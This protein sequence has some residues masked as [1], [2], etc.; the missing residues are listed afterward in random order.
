MCSLLCPAWVHRCEY[1]L[2]GSSG[3]FFSSSV[4][5]SDWMCTLSVRSGNQL[6]FWKLS[7]KEF[8]VFSVGWTDTDLH[9]FFFIWG[10]ED[11]LQPEL[12]QT[13][14]LSSVNGYR[15]FNV[16]FGEGSFI[17]IFFSLRYF[18]SCKQEYS[19]EGN[20]LILQILKGRIQNKFLLFL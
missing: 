17:G 20:F 10:I 3:S 13:L 18:F 12:S 11:V 19:Q 14:E 7:V 15:L 5:F 9:Q 2:R 4:S 16:S 8:S 1:Q 6:C